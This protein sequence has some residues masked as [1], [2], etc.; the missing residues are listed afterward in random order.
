MDSINS[1]VENI[2]QII[3]KDGKYLSTGPNGYFWIND[4]CFA[5]CWKLELD[6]INKLFA[7]KLIDLSDA[8]LIKVKKTIITTEICY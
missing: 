2:T 6:D 1:T 5:V 3:T 4:P 8:K 7:C